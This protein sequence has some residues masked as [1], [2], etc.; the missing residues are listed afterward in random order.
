PV[1]LSN[2]RAFEDDGV[3]IGW[4]L[5]K[6]REYEAARFDRPDGLSRRH[7]QFSLWPPRLAQDR[8]VLARPLMPVDDGKAPARLQRRV[9]GSRQ[10]RLIGDAVQG[11]R[12]EHEI[13][14]PARER[15]EFVG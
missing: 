2:G 10:A 1:F 9:Y 13:D 3:V 14:Q 6:F 15:G 4:Q 7:P 8:G 5:D 11:V 12:H